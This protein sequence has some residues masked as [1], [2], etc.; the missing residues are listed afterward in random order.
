M[1]HNQITELSKCNKNIY[2]QINTNLDIISNTLATEYEKLN[3]LSNDLPPELDKE[4]IESLKIFLNKFDKSL[5]D[6]R[7][8]IDKIDSKIIEIETNTLEFIK[9]LGSSLKGNTLNVK[10]SLELDT[11]NEI[12][13]IKERINTVREMSSNLIGM[14][15]EFRKISG[16]DEIE[17]KRIEQVVKRVL[18]GEINEFKRELNEGMPSLSN[19]NSNLNYKYNELDGK[20]AHIHNKLNGLY[21]NFDN[22]NKDMNNHVINQNKLLSNLQTDS[23]SRKTEI[24]NLYSKLTDDIDQVRYELNSRIRRLE[25]LLFNNIKKY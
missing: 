16:L 13:S 4:S 20:C 1:Q 24:E 18:T 12:Q 6:E 19:L 11:I 3:E 21:D 14:S 9:S 8:N 15:E 25:D 5:Q 23:Y 17:L 22:L 7:I 2:N 10:N